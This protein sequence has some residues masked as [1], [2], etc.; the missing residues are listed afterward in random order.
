MRNRIGTVGVCIALAGAVAF[1]AGLL[2]ASNRDQVTWQAQ[3][4]DGCNDTLNAAVWVGG[5]YAAVDSS[6]AILTSPNGV[7]WTSRESSASDDLVDVTWNGHRFVLNV[8]P[9]LLYSAPHQPE[10]RSHERRS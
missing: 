8:R 1:V 4:V 10:R 5:L 2:N 9:D 3:S 6:G 7:D